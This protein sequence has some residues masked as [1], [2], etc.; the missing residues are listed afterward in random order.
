VRLRTK[1]TDFFLLGSESN[2]YG[3]ALSSSGGYVSLQDWPSSLV[4]IRNHLA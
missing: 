3:L 4:F 1:G 2:S